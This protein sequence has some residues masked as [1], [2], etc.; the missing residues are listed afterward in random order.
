MRSISMI[1][2]ASDQKSKRQP[3]APCLGG[4]DAEIVKDMLSW[5]NPILHRIY[6][7]TI[8]KGG[9]TMTELFDAFLRRAYSYR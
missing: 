2:S 4:K 3:E 7:V 5:Y 1:W 9:K 6:Q 8:C